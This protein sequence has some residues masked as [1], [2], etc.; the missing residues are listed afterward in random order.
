MTTKI[1]LCFV[2]DWKWEIHLV[3]PYAFFYQLMDTKKNYSTLNHYLTRNNANAYEFTRFFFSTRH[4]I[5]G[6][7]V[8]MSLLKRSS[9]YARN[10]D[11]HIANSREFFSAMSIIVTLILEFYG[12]LLLWKWFT[13]MTIQKFIQYLH[14]NTHTNAHT[15]THTHTHTHSHTH[16]YTHKQT[17]TQIYKHTHIHTYT[18]TNKYTHTH[19]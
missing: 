14:K 10:K 12:L 8:K 1:P 13:K 6:H 5:R 7:S 2:P 16:T 9:R 17:H 3:Q 19:T 11:N 4:I 18:H 15:H